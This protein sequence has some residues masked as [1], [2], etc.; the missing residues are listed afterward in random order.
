MAI[1]VHVR[2]K[3]DHRNLLLYYIDPRTGREVS[4]SAGT[5]ELREAD[6][7]AARWEDE[8]KQYRGESDDGWLYFRERFREEHLATLSRRSHGSYRT[9]LNHFERLMGQI[10]MSEITARTIGD[11]QS[12]LLAE[13]RPLSSIRNYL[14]HIRAAVNWAN[15]VEMIDRA[16]MVKLPKQVTRQFMRGRPLTEVEYKRM[17]K[18]CDALEDGQDWRRM[19]ELLWLSGMRLGEAIA[20]SWTKPPIVVDLEGGEYPQ[21]LFYGEANKSRR[22]D[23]VPMTPELVAWLQKTPPKARKGLVA[24]VRL[25]T[26]ER[27][28]EQITAIGKAA[29]VTVND[30]DKWASAH[31]LRRSF[32]TR[33]ARLVMPMTLQ[34]M[35]RHSELSTT[36][37]YYV[38]LSSADAARAI[39]EAAGVPASVPK[40]GRRGRNAG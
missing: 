13:K 40:K 33:W 7:A 17:L 15:E 9:A 4:K 35:M 37:K 30:Q 36:L 39:W 12:K 38:G 22:D 5:R 14:T 28:S 25:E 8:L 18:A 11:F 23:A 3:G 26:L 21:I 6:K 10:P 34:R 20:L 2:F 32:G 29:A 1:K 16:P 27:I 19:L 24:P 31:D